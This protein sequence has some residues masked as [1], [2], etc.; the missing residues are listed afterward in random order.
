MK[1]FMSLLLLSGVSGFSMAADLGPVRQAPAAIK[2]DKDYNLQVD[3]GYLFNESKNSD[4]SKTSKQNLTGSVLLQRGSGVWGQELRIDAVNTNDDSSDN[5]IERYLLSG[6][7]SHHQT[8]S[9]YQFVKLQWEKDLSSSFDYQ[10]SLTGGFG[11]DFIRDDKQSLSGELGVGYRNSKDSEPP[12]HDNNEAIGTAALFY[13]RA[14][15][16]TLKFQ[17][18]LGYEY[19]EEAGVFR[20][21]TALSAAINSHFAAQAGYQLKQVNAGLG[22]SRD[23]FV[24]LGLKYIH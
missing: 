14:I 8:A 23:S 5:N 10:A 20:S 18:D 11:Y 19:G 4:G 16:P 3:A 15:T 24:S 22:N 6:K 17:Q 2:L 21:K 7:V 1:S 9:V 13:E 12:R